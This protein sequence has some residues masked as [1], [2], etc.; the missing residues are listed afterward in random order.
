[1]IKCPKCNELIGDN[2][3]E[4]PFCKTNISEEERN[5]ATEEN[6]RVHREAVEA[7]IKEY[8]RRTR[9]GIIVAVIMVLLAVIG[10]TLIYSLELEVFW[11]FALFLA[12]ALIY[13]VSVLKLRI[14]LCPYCESFMGRGILFRS[15]CPR[16][17]GKLTR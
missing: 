3:T 10:V 7:S 17:G 16:C 6:E 11:I 15:H 9:N 4:C 14:G 1:M 2:V 12:I 5:R 8:Y 13:T